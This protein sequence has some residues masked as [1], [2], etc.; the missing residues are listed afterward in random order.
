MRAEKQIES[1][2]MVCG[3]TIQTLDLSPLK[4]PIC[5][6]VLPFAAF[7]CRIFAFFVCTLEV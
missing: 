7:F 2:V 4:S 3:Q 1:E 6:K 5:G